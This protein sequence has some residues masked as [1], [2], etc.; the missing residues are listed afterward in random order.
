MD[1]TAFPISVPFPIW[2]KQKKY[3]RGRHSR[4]ADLNQA[5][6]VTRPEQRICPQSG[7]QKHWN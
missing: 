6:F 5:S 1:R 2:P 7:R 3:D 4:A